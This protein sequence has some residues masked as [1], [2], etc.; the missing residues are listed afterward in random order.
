MTQMS[1]IKSICIIFI[2]RQFKLFIVALPI[3]F[4]G[5]AIESLGLERAPIRLGTSQD[6][7]SA[8]SG[9]YK[10]NI[11]PSA[12]WCLPKPIDGWYLYSKSNMHGSD[13]YWVPEAEVVA[14]FPKS[15]DQLARE[16]YVVSEWCNVGFSNWEKADPNRNNASL[17]LLYLREADQANRAK[18][19]R[20]ESR[21]LWLQED[22]GFGIAYQ[23][24]KQFPLVQLGEW[25]YLS[26]VII[27][28]AWPW[29]RS[30]RA[31][32]W[33]IH[34]ALIPLLLLLP[35]YLGYCAWNFTSAGPGGGVLYPL[36]LDGLSPLPWTSLDSTLIQSLPHPLASLTGPLGSMISFS[37]HNHAGPIAAICL[38]LV[39]GLCVSTIGKAIPRLRK[40]FDC[41]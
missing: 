21:L 39:L 23:R 12:S 29:L 26:F 40:G 19:W 28:T 4:L 11:I 5:L 17:L 2:R 14:D 8:A 9:T 7:W 41:R 38:G 3:L 20:P 25:L 31:W 6:Y 37:H 35:F 18:K 10:R 22:L 13:F 24:Q 36:V 15:A 30:S 34:F 32:V 1:K 27:F 16:G 33:A